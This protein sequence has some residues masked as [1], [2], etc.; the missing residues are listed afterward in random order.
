M[1]TS[2]TNSQRIALDVVSLDGN[3]HQRVYMAPARNAKSVDTRLAATLHFNE[4][5]YHKLPGSNTIVV[6]GTST[7][8]TVKHLLKGPKP[9]ALNWGNGLRDRKHRRTVLTLDGQVLSDE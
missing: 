4:V 5:T 3:N 6:L 1:F 9:L 7:T 2:H 8:Q